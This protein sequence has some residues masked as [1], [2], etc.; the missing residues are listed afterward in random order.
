MSD[1]PSEKVGGSSQ[2]ALK[3]GWLAA[4]IGHAKKNTS[5]VLKSEIKI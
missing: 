3:V 1:L 4:T 2:Y 5:Y